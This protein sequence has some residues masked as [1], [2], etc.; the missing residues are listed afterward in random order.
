MTLK[1]SWNWD[2]STL[3]WSSMQSFTC[4]PLEFN[5]VL[6]LQVNILGKPILFTDWTTN[7]NDKKKISVMCHACSMSYFIKSDLKLHK[8][9]VRVINGHLNEVGRGALTQ[10][11][12]FLNLAKRKTPSTIPNSNPIF[13]TETGG[14]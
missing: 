12:Q 8:V 6:A 4:L 9:W 1:I 2:L 5:T 14:P 10:S 13:T 3:S 7:N 11:V